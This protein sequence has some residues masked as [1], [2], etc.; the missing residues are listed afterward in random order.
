MRP[1]RSQEPQPIP[2]KLTTVSS[3]YLLPPRGRPRVASTPIG[4][5]GYW[6][7]VTHRGANTSKIGA[8]FWKN[9]LKIPFWDI[10]TVRSRPMARVLLG[11]P[12]NLRL[13]VW[14]VYFRIETTTQA[15]GRLEWGTRVPHLCLILA[16]A[17]KVGSIPTSAK[18]AQIWGTSRLEWGTSE[19]AALQID[20]FLR[21]GVAAA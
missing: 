9:S 15:N 17:S 4:E 13:F 16:D 1:G 6:P 20:L 3:S 18:G 10:T 11:G 8:G 2:I 5:I 19:H 7:K 21:L 14:G 12:H